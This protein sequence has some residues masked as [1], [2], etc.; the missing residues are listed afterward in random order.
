MNAEE[1]LQNKLDAE[2]E[3]AAA[4]KKELDTLKDH[5]DKIDDERSKA[6]AAYHECHGALDK[7][8][9]IFQM[10]G[11][12]TSKILENV[13]ALKS[14]VSNA[15]WAEYQRI[16]SENRTIKHEYNIRVERLDAIA[17]ALGLDEHHTMSFEI[18][19]KVEQLVEKTKK[20]VAA[21]KDIS[22]RELQTK[23]P[24]TVH[25]HR[26]FRASPMTHKDFGH[27]LLHIFKAAGKLA[28]L[29]NDAEHG[30]CEFTAEQADRYVADMVVC[31]LRM[32]N[33]CPGR[34]IDLQSSVVARIETKNDV[35]LTQP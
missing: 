10:E 1:R 15:E 23:L 28:A 14:K 19:A 21:A 11:W 20:Q 7:I 35:K 32:A 18:V 12:N 24:W 22:L 3:K 13:K 6:W 25:Y 4:L 26:D 2:R 5:Y 29:V 17:R 34:V 9:D 27:A 16:A 30:G 33:T 31:A 8:A